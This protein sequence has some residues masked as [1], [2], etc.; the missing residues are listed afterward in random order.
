MMLKDIRPL[1]VADEDAQWSQVVECLGEHIEV[2][3]LGTYVPAARRGLAYWLRCVVA[4]TV[5]AGIRD[6][7]V[8]VY[9][10]VSAAARY[11]PRTVGPDQGRRRLPRRI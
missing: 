8:V 11:V 4:R 5:D 1:A 10:L 2:V 9:C 7:L 3:S 6:G